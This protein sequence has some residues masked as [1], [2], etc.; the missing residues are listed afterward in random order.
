MEDL[1]ALIVFGNDVDINITVH[2]FIINIL[3]L[4]QVISL[5]LKIDNFFS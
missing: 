1:T 5:A 2:F 4:K 3:N